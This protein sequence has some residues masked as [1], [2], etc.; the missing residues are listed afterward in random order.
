MSGPKDLDPSSRRVMIGEE[1]RH[2]RERADLT[3]QALGELLF[4]SGSYVGQMEAGTRR[5]LPD[6]AV[7]LD[8][9]L[10]AGGFFVRHCTKANQ[11]KHPEYFAEAA[12]AEALATGIRQYGAM[13][14]PGLL[15]TSDYARAV[16]LDYQ[17]TAPDQAIEELLASR[18]SRTRLLDHPTKPQLWAVLDEAVLRRPVGSA[19]VMAENL[20]HIANLVRTRRIIAQVIPFAA[21]GHASPHGSLKLMYFDDAPPLAFIEAPVT[22]LLLDDP[23]AVNRLELSY[24]LLRASA[25]TPRKSLALISSVAED[26]AHGDHETRT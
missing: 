20:Q 14:I 3:Q 12:E 26:Y 21:G 8:E 18:M 16:F 13:L 23:A 25:L 24:D 2:A 9:I 15:Q 4:V 5:I 6:M 22:G 17:P 1:L 11:S 19:S 7:R 10:K